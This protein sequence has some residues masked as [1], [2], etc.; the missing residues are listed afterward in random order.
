MISLYDLPFIFFLF[1]LKPMISI[2][3]M[4]SDKCVNE[5][6]MEFIILDRNSMLLY[7][8]LILKCIP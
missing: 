2:V 6:D 8:N 1:R 7:E 3:I 5:S 4:Y